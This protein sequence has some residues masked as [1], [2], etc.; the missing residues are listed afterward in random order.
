MREGTG[1][2]HG[3]DFKGIIEYSSDI[4]IRCGYYDKFMFI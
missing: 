1:R 4:G 2:Y 3:G